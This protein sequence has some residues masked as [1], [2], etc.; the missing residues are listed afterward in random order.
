MIYSIYN[1]KN[2]LLTVITYI[3]AVITFFAGSLL[4][5]L[6]ILFGMNRRKAFVSV[7]RPWAAA[8]LKVAGIKLT[9]SG[10]E[11]VSFDGPKV[12]VS[13]HQG[14]FD[15]PILISVLPLD[16]RFLVKKELFRVPFF[17]WYLKGRGDIPIDR[18]KGKKAHH[19]L[20]ISAELVKKGSPMLIFPEGTRS[21]DGS[22]GR[23]KRGSL[24]LAYDSGAK[25]M[26]V[27]I[28]GSFDIQK[29]GGFMIS[30]SIVSVNIGKPVDI[31]MNSDP[32]GNINDQGAEIVRESIISLMGS[33]QR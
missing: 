6:L 24:V 18:E 31:S 12:I 22:L 20:K 1:M 5:L 7:S 9:V 2:L 21:R 19:T 15:I 28:N 33:G 26:P 4:V 25:I 17:G 30:P 8:V 13:N 14:N 32:S 27:G 10:L 16:F 29:K 3:F 11:N 23:F